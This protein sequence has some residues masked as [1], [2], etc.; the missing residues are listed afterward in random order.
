P[1]LTRIQAQAVVWLAVLGLIALLQA[2]KLP[3]GGSGT[4]AFVP[5]LASALIAPNLLT[6]LAVAT[7]HAI[8]EAF[9]KRGVLKAGFN[10]AQTS[11]ATS[12]GILVFLGLGG[13]PLQRHA[14]AS[15]LTLTT[16]TIGPFLALVAV[17]FV[18]NTFAV[19]GVIAASSKRKVLS[20][21]KD[22]TFS[23]L[24]YDVLSA[25]VVFLF[26]WVYV[27]TGVIGALGLALPLLGARQLYK[28][29][30]QLEQLTQE[31]LQLMV[32]AIEARDPYTSGHS[33]RVAHYSGIIARAVG[34]NS[35]LINRVAVAA[36]LHDVGKIHEVY[37]PIL[38]KPG[39]LTPDEWAIM[40]THP[41]KS[42][43]LVSMVSD[44]RNLVGAIRHHHE[45][46]DGSGY[47]DQIAAEAI[48]VESR[49][50][51]F[52][53]TID[54]MT[55]DRPYRKALGEED[56][57]RE[58]IKYRGTQFDPEI[59]DKLLASTMF[60]MLFQTVDMDALPGGQRSLTPRSLKIVG[61]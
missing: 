30:R 23:T 47:P 50:I 42:A 22:S 36:L 27:R 11:F 48:P 21:W 29:N 18:A 59:C 8:A 55:S 16:A 37:A 58:L 32:K 45:N 12:M 57:R 40:K 28:T 33:R 60:G 25:P 3:G 31:L 7:T 4:I 15:L 46:W 49:V 44:L 9:S 20:V 56:V 24:I 38:R 61:A 34:M 13:I 39:R 10:I 53:D 2:H 51:M 43:E 26:A 5:I 17:F 6:V 1:E 52:A 35:K 19:S 14:Q 41:V 54:A